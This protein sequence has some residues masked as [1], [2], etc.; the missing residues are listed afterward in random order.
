MKRE[1]NFFSEIKLQFLICNSEYNS[2]NVCIYSRRVCLPFTL[3]WR[4][5]EL[6]ELSLEKKNFTYLLQNEITFPEINGKT[7]TVTETRSCSH[8]RQSW[9]DI[10]GFSLFGGCDRFVSLALLPYLRLHLW[11]NMIVHC[12]IPSG[13]I[14][15]LSSRTNISLSVV[16][17]YVIWTG[18][19]VA[20]CRKNVSTISLPSPFDFIS[21]DRL[22]N[23]LSGHLLPCVSYD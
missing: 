6:E 2:L 14:V 21:T 19:I 4:M 23:P 18:F 1:K 15:S 11:F 9:S 20:S 8:Y 12:Y 13:Y 3:G 17:T 16:V 7:D 10:G 5:E 22:L